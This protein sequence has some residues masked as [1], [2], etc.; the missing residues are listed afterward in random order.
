MASKKDLS[1]ASFS[2]TDAID[3]PSG[4]MLPSL[5]SSPFPSAGCEDRLSCFG[6]AVFKNECL[7]AMRLNILALRGQESIILRHDLCIG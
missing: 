6:N 7:L 2:N 3:G 5:L 1:F 4:C